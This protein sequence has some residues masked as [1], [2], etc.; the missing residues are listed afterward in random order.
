MQAWNLL[1]TS[2]FCSYRVNV[3][4]KG[5]ISHHTV[6]NL[7]CYVILNV[8]GLIFGPLP[9]ISLTRL[10]FKL[11]DNLWS[12]L[13]TDIINGIPCLFV[14]LWPY[15]SLETQR[16]NQPLSWSSLIIF[17]LWRCDYHLVHAAKLQ[18]YVQGDVLITILNLFVFTNISTTTIV[19]FHSCELTKSALFLP[20]LLLSL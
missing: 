4:D 11:I 3:K 12:I 9:H 16:G 13:H 5:I 10:F 18:M 2:H 20:L 7:S 15:I 19:Y 6:S 17:W 8:S 14:F 1:R